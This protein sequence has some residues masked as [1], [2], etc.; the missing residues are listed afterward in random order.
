MLDGLA[1]Y[2][3]DNYSGYNQIPITPE[4]QEKTTLTRPG[5]VPC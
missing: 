1:G 5:N 4:D 3:L 2:D